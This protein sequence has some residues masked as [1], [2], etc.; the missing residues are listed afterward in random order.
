MKHRRAKIVCTLGPAV[1]DES[2]LSA[3]V[4]A[5]MDVAR[6]NF[7]H[8]T[9]EEHARR[10]EQLR[11]VTAGGKA[12]SILQDLCG[13]KIRT[14][15]DGP[16]EV[17]TGAHVRLAG[18]EGAPD[19]I[20]VSYDRVASDLKPGD[21]VLLGD[22]AVELKVETVS[23]TSVSCFVE[24]GGP[25]R[26]RMGVNLPSERIALPAITD[27]DED[28]LAFGLEMGV[29]YVA[30]SF[31]RSV[32]DLKHLREL[33][34]K[35][36]RPDVP[37]VAK[38]ETPAAVDHI[39]GIASEADAVMVARGDLGVELPPEVVPSL[40]KRIIQTCRRTATPVIVATEML[41]SMV[42][43]PRP[44]R[45][46]ASDVANAVFDGTDAVM[47]SAET[48]TGAHPQRACA[49]M[50]RII[51]D[52]ESSAFFR[53]Q[54]AELG[55]NTPQAIAGAACDIAEAVGAAGV[56]CFT[57]SGLT[58]RLVSESRP[59]VPVFGF[60]P[61]AKTVRKLGLYWGVEPAS[62]D[63]IPDVDE[64]VRQVLAHLVE[65]DRLASGDRVVVVYGAPVG[66]RGS[67]NSLR[68]ETIP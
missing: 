25:L 46:E 62:F 12:V 54:R 16:A 36:G 28:D 56:L 60:S 32:A 24:H 4:A 19:T 45:A 7:S 34:E 10:A 6:F 63:M 40:Q 1:D 66:Q 11:R 57:A 39:E 37:I 47:L 58:A 35:H 15:S 68:V 42:D 49:M 50:A 8:G 48:A 55:G 65:S 26:A 20:G 23:E 43:S 61:D 18:G 30:L 17:V 2:S 22:G 21:R 51:A 59:L 38:V 5:G 67:T 14:G 27:R 9:H 29:D 41:Q 53:S 3:L 33:C 44:T 52:A 13:P 64:L 31:V